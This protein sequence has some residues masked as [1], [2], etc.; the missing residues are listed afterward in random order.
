MKTAI[1]THVPWELPGLIQTEIARSG[2]EVVILTPADLPRFDD[3]YQQSD[4]VVI[5]GGPMSANNDLAFLRAEERLIR[6][7]VE[8]EKPLLGVCLGSQLMAKALGGRVYPNPVKEIGWSD[9]ELTPEAAGDDLLTG[10][11]N[12]FSVLQWHGETFDLP[13]G[14]VLLAS[15]PLCRN[16]AFRFGKSAW[17][18]QFHIETTQDMLQ[19]WLAE[20]A[21]CGDLKY[22]A[23]PID[24]GRT[25]GETAHIVLGRWASLAR[26]RSA[27]VVS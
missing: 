25:A 20:P 22:A 7:A 8:D 12:K 4:S 2:G 5:M 16:Q 9:V 24:P 14:A 11:P 1:F 27:R 19:A 26:N 3:V 13:A 21:M 6:S 18:F 17:G 10:L 23:G 15:S